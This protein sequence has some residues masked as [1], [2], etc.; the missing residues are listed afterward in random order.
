MAT[1]KTYPVSAWVRTVVCL[2]P[3]VIAVA[4]FITFLSTGRGSLLVGSSLTLC[5]AIARQV[6]TKT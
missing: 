4:A 1:E 5:G 6:F 2:A 3:F